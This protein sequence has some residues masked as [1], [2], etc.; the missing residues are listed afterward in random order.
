MQTYRFLNYNFILKLQLEIIYF[1]SNCSFVKSVVFLK[2][3]WWSN[4]EP[5]CFG[6]LANGHQY[7]RTANYSC[8]RPDLHLTLTRRCN[9]I[10]S[11]KF[12]ILM[13]IVFFPLLFFV[14]TFVEAP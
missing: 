6:P 4:A 12:I 9:V 3:F 1:F 10:L 2:T 7:R 14:Y 5:L 8:V 13:F 11:C